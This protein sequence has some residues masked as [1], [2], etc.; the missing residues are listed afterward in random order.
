MR[1]QELFEG[2]FNLEEA[3][4]LSNAAQRE[5][6]K[7]W[8]KNRW[9]AIFNK[10]YRIYIP[11]EISENVIN[12]NIEVVNYLKSLGYSVKDY[13]KN[14]AVDNNGREKR[15][16]SLVSKDP[17]IKK[18]YDN[19]PARIGAKQ[20]NQM[21]VISRHPVDIAG[22]STGKGWTSCMNLHD[23]VEKQYV[24]IDIQEGTIIAY[25]TNKDDK[26]I[27]NASARVLIKPFI[28]INKDQYNFKKPNDDKIAL[29]ISNVIYGTTNDAFVK[30]VKQWV[31]NVNKSH[32]LSGLFYLNPELYDRDEHKNDDVSLKPLEF[33]DGHRI[34][35]NK[36]ISDDILIGEYNNYKLY[37]TSKKY[38]KELTFSD[39]LAYVKTIV[40]SGNKNYRIPTTDEMQFIY[41]NKT[42]IPES[43]SLEDSYYYTIEDNDYDDPDNINANIFDFSDADI[44]DYVQT[45]K[46]QYIRP[47]RLSGV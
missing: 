17:N 44:N 35:P 1:L 8:N 18:I 37:M 46:E 12:P 5:L 16:G 39:G 9:S 36:D 47:V 26:Y 28:S 19:D 43:E 31:N 45:W 20:S 11:L 29:G 40:I 10:K 21:V 4:G 3:F 25:L 14:M 15:I 33:K 42:K 6:F 41:D 38:E 30:T 27:K 7:N 23:G 32:K 22:M 2:M 24:P 13:A 34:K